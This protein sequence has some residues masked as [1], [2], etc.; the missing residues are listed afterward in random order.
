MKN[1]IFIL[2]VLGSFLT[3]A[4]SS[5]DDQYS[6]R[7]F[8]VGVINA[9]KQPVFGEQVENELI[10][11][12]LANPRF[13][14]LE[15]NQSGFKN[16]LAKLSSPNLHPASTE[17][18]KV[19]EDIFKDQ[20]VKGTRAVILGEVIKKDE[21]EYELGLTLATTA[22]GEMI[23]HEKVTVS[24]PKA[25]E[26]F[27][28][29][30][31]EAMTE[32]IKKIPFDA[33]ILKRDG[34]LVV[35]DRGARVFRPGTQVSVFTTELKDGKLM[36]EETGLIGITQVEENLT[37]GKVMV[38]KRPHE[39][40]KGNK[41]Q[42]S[43]SPPMEVGPLLAAGEGRE[44]ASLWGNEFEVKKGKLGTVNLDL[45]PSL[46]TL[47]NVSKSGN[48]TSATKLITGGTFNGELWLT[49]KYYLNLGFNYGV[50][51]I[52]NS[53][54]P[55]TEPVGMAVSAFKLL[56]GYRLNI[57]APSTGPIVYFRGGYGTQSFSISDVKGP[58]IFNSVSY[59]GPMISGGVSV[60]IDDK[61]GIGADISTIIFPSVSESPLAASISYSN[62]AAW[63]VL[64]KAT[65]NYQK[66]FD[67]DGKLMF[68][69]FGSD[70][71]GGAGTGAS[72]V[73]TS[74]VTKGLILGLTYYY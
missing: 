8:V 7:G 11:L 41:V 30:T 20:Y 29:A 58:V 69:R 50:A 5:L 70:V 40:A 16:E 74:Q 43:D 63:T 52:V 19:Y 36:L 21:E 28:A 49:S 67:F 57:F 39:V 68:Q 66:D 55:G 31:R 26:S 60:P 42:F 47:S 54:A 56:V 37:F 22:T 51:S 23:A 32:L 65:Y 4:S 24:N 12:L 10:S 59:A 45:G 62:V 35:L 64:L 25:L 6:Y 18:L 71:S 3:F 38:E 48:S 72:I 73:S 15:K 2:F 61:I 17:K 34:Y 13:D 53:K 14:Y 44:P 27:S 9:K 33:S 1:A 46:V